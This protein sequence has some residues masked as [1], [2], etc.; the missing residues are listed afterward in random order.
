MGCA[1][2]RGVPGAE[3]NLMVIEIMVVGG[4][5]GSH[6]LG[7]SQYVRVPLIILPASKMA[8]SDRTLIVKNKEI[9]L[10]FLLINSS[11]RFEI[12]SRRRLRDIS[13]NI[14]DSKL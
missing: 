3:Q 7:A 2:G 9:Y 4:C 6:I 12:C 10:D 5:Y 8:V 13:G 14:G 1:P 11:M